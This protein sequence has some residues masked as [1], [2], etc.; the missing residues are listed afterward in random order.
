MMREE[1]HKHK[2]LDAIQHLIEYVELIMNGAMESHMSDSE[3]S[4]V[5]HGLSVLNSDITRS[6]METNHERL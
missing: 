3:T 1:W 6:L 2:T 5:Y 4:N